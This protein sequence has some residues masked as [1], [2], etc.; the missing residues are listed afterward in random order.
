MILGVENH[1]LDATAF[2]EGG[3][4]LRFFDRGGP[5]QHRAPQFIE[6]LGLIGYRIEFLPLRTV[7]QIRILAPN[8]WL[9]GGSNHNLELVDLLE[10]SGFRLGCSRHA[11]QLVVHTEV[12]LKGDGGQGLVLAFDAHTLLRLQRLVQAV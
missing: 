10:L 4:P 7:H 5:Y 6:F 1:M 3:E 8:Q 2:Q 9:V 11:C 12:V